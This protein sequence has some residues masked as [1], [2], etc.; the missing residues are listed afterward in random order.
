MIKVMVPAT[1]ANI[2]PGFD[3]LGLALNIY[4]SFKVEEIEKG[5][6]ILGCDDEFKNENNMIYSAMVKTFEITGYRPKGIRI[7]IEGNI[8]VS[9]G[10]G[11][12]ASCIVGGVLAANELSKGRLNIKDVINIA[13]QIEG[14]PDN[15]TPAI[16]GGM[17]A[18]IMENSDVLYEKINILEDIK[19]CAIIPSFRLSTQK[20]REVLPKM[21]SFKDGV[22]NISRTALLISSLINK[23]YDLIKYAL[24]DR[25]HQIY[26]KNL[27]EGYDDIVEKCYEYGAL[28]AFLSGA[29]PTI[30]AILKEDDNKFVN[31]IE[32]Y[33]KSINKSWK[34]IEMKID[35]Q[36]AVVI[37]N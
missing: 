1:C 8:P 24:E 9:R 26:R 32:D 6:E 35:K 5:I 19:F 15:T 7:E 18:S 17:T 14:H 11:S 28:G 25:M 30:M 2:G 3:C 10:L 36:G 12:S 16:V 20:A 31:K 22:Y 29:G 23:N 21:I 13:A 27:I 33:L 4:N 37:R 34:A